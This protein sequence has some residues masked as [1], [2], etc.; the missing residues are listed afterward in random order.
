MQSTIGAP[1]GC[2]LA[3]L[4]SSASVPTGTYVQLAVSLAG[5]NQAQFIPGGTKCGGLMANCA[6]L[7]DGSVN[8]LDTVATGS[9]SYSIPAS[10]IA[11]GQIVLS[12]SSSQTLNIDFD[13]CA[14]MFSVTSGYGMDPTMHAALMPSA[15]SIAGRLL[16]INTRQP[17][18]GDAIVALELQ[19]NDGIDREIMQT[20]SGPDGGFILC[21]VPSGTYDVVAVA[22][23]NAGV[24]YAATVTTGV[25]PGDTL[26][27]VLLQPAGTANPAPASISGQITAS[28]GPP[29]NFGGYTHVVVSALQ[30]V[31]RGNSTVF[32]T[33]PLASQYSST[34]RTFVTSSNSYQLEVPA[35]NPRVGA[36]VP[37]GITTYQQ[38]ASSPPGYQ[39]EVQSSCNPASVQTPSSVTVVP[40][41]SVTA[42]LLALTGC[43]PA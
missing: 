2:V 7:S 26:G 35:A 33:I 42:P 34:L 19:D 15:G 43:P 24:A 18:V 22:V 32:A 36:F 20:S 4:S 40:G 25:Q 23:S 10:Q 39:V 11:G 14:S 29:T 21:P 27:D 16:D 9:Q 13:S 30:T 5:S 41:S 37:G 3:T 12:S 28:I 8:D 17:V 31:T 6:V 38:D 1:T